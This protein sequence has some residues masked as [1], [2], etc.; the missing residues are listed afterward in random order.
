MPQDRRLSH[1]TTRAFR[2]PGPWPNPGETHFPRPPPLLCPPLPSP[3]PQES[4][5]GSVN[6]LE[7][8]K[9]RNLDPPGGRAA[10]GARAASNQHAPEKP[11]NR[12]GRLPRP[13]PRDKRRVRPHLASPGDAATHPAAA[14]RTLRSRPWGPPPAEAPSRCRVGVSGP[15]PRSERRREPRPPGGAELPAPRGR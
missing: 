9:G 2:R 4:S 6:P 3:A 15:E 14:G 13:P 7:A 8:R 1:P 12:R 11:G 5:P 10:G